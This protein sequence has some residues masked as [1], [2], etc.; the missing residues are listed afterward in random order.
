MTILERMP[1]DEPPAAPA[2]QDAGL[3]LEAPAVDL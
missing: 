1:P 3:R 2:F